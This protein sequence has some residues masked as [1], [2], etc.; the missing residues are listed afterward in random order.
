MNV[1]PQPG[2]TVLHQWA[3]TAHLVHGLPSGERLVA[4]PV[5]C[6]R[7]ATL[8][9]AAEMIAQRNR[10]IAEHFP[11]VHLRVQEITKGPFAQAPMSDDPLAPL[12]KFF[13]E[14]FMHWLQSEAGR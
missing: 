4:L 3:V 12:G 10:Q 13:A 1:N 5:F 9:G 14:R 7:N 8:T 6:V 11:S 2:Q